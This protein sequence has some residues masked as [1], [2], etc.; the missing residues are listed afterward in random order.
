MSLARFCAC[1]T[2][3]KY[4]LPSSFL[5]LSSPTPFH[6]F[7]QTILSLRKL[8]TLFDHQLLYTLFLTVRSPIMRLSLALVLAGGALGAIIQSLSDSFGVG[9]VVC[10]INTPSTSTVTKEVTVFNPMEATTTAPS[11]TLP[12]SSGV[13]YFSAENGTTVWYNGISPSETALIIIQTA[14]IDVTEVPSSSTTGTTRIITQ[15]TTATS[16][17]T[18]TVVFTSSEVHFSIEAVQST[19]Q[20]STVTVLGTITHTTFVALAQPSETTAK[21]NITSI[22]TTSTQANETILV[23]EMRPVT[24][25]MIV[26][27]PFSRPI[28]GWNITSPL[29]DTPIAVNTT[30]LTAFSAVNEANIADMTLAYATST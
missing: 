11:F 22:N 18:S 30:L 7:G 1:W 20:P 13:Y 21:S 16:V 25:T 29:N 15:I 6:S 10:G 8:L 27:S 19:V 3:H 12:S 2:A 28:S 26:H 4:V 5:R 24:H 9:G 23:T 17:V 14:T